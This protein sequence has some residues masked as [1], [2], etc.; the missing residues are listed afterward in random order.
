[1]KKYD[2]YIVLVVYVLLLLGCSIIEPELRKMSHQTGPY[3]P[4][5]AYAAL[6]V[7]LIVL[8]IVLARSSKMTVRLVI[9]VA[10][11]LLFLGAAIW[12][13]IGASYVGAVIGLLSGIPSASTIFKEIQ[14]HRR[15][16]NASLV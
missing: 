14:L 12:H 10:V 13:L 1:M 11:L 2:E 3:I 16:T 15:K 7:L 4:M 5:K 6:F 9:P 8:N